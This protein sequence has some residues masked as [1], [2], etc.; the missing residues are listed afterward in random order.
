MCGCSYDLSE[1][2]LMKYVCLNLCFPFNTLFRTEKIQGMLASFGSASFV[3]PLAVWLQEGG[4]T[5]T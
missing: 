4:K 2:L 1:G 5:G 3:L